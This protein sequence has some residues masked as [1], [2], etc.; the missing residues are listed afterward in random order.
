MRSNARRL[1]L[2]A[3][4]VGSMVSVPPPAA[5]GKVSD[6]ERAEQAL[7]VA[8][9]QIGDPYKYGAEGPEKIDGSGLVYFAARKAGF[10]GVPRT[11]GEQADHMRRI[12]RSKLRRGDFVFFTEKGDVYHVGFY[13]GRRDGDRMI[14]HAPSTGEDV[15]RGQIW[16]DKWFAATLRGA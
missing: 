15:S 8:K 11:S 1:V 14:V 6:G 5:A 16:T 7:R 4:L 9:R 2:T 3:A 10:T 12:K 13:V